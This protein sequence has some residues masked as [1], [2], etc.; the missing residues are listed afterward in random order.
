MDTDGNVTSDQASSARE[1]SE[2]VFFDKFKK[3]K[4]LRA[5]SIRSSQCDSFWGTLSNFD[6]SRGFCEKKLPCRVYY[7]SPI[8]PSPVPSFAPGA[9]PHEV[10]TMTGLQIAMSPGIFS[11]PLYSIVIAAGQVRHVPY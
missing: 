6:Y 8:Y 4:L 2:D 7:L 11:W 1:V 9:P 10:V 3:D 5:T